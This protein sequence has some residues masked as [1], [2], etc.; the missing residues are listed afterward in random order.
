MKLFNEIT[1]YT[2]QQGWNIYGSLVPKTR[3]SNRVFPGYLSG[4][5][6]HIIT[7]GGRS[8]QL[9]GTGICTMNWGKGTAYQII[10]SGKP[11]VHSSAY[12]IPGR[13]EISLKGDVALLTLFHANWDACMRGDIKA[14][15]RLL[16]L[17][18][19]VIER[20]SLVGHIDS[21]QSM[22]KLQIC[23]AAGTAIGGS[24]GRLPAGII[25][26]DVSSTLV[27]GDIGMLAEAHEL[28]YINLRDSLAGTY[29][30]RDLSGWADEIVLLCRNLPLESGAVDRLLHDLRLT[31]IIN[32]TLDISGT[33]GMPSPAGLADIVV[34]KLRGWQ[35]TPNLTHAAFASYE[36]RFSDTAAH[37][38]EA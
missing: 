27:G 24:L 15:E 33:T 38:A 9:C 1:R 35:V 21:L 16:G 10:G 26:F 20:T 3:W 6:Y 36:I 13:Y 37:F 17:E 31:T 34:L 5:F 2:P 25:Y 7:P 29:N 14:F 19:L 4:L 18:E 12:S 28:L 8:I 32:G 30:S 23:K 22:P 11:T